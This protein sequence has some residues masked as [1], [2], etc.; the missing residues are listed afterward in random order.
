MPPVIDL[1]F[2]ALL[3]LEKAEPP[4]LLRLP[5]GEQYLNHLGTVHASAQ[6]S[7][8]E[9]SSAEFLAREFALLGPCIPIVRRFESKFRKPAHGVIT[10]TAAIPEQIIE[11][12]RRDFEA[13]GRGSIS[14][15]VQLHDETGAHTLSATV[16]WFIT[17]V[18]HARSHE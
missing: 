12:F 17:R 10:S 8:A 7:L 11:G 15:T 14:V 9:A 1:P 5:K 3:Q 13:K 2:N 4:L 16:E 18:P 6:L